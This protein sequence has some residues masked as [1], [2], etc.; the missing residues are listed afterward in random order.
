MGLFEIASLLIGAVCGNL[1]A[2]LF[3]PV[4]LG[5]VWNT[6]LG[7]VGAGGYLF[8]LPVIGVAQFGFWIYDYVA[9]GMAGLALVLVIGGLVE[10]LCARR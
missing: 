5:L 1:C 6:V 10:Y 2:V 8:A 9:A 4:N 7:L 3:P